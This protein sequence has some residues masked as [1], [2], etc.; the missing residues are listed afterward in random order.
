MTAVAAATT[1]R[2]TNAVY[3]PA[4]GSFNKINKTTRATNATYDPK[5]GSFKKTSAAEPTT[6]TTVRTTR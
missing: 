6:K 4:T 2:T 5:T 3:D 1:K